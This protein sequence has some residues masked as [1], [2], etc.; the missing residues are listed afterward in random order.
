[1]QVPERLVSTLDKGM[2]VRLEFDAAPTTTWIGTI[3]HV[4]PQADLLSRSFPVKVLLDNRLRDGSPVLR[5]GMLARAWLPVGLVGEALVVPKDAVVL[6]GP[7]PIVFAVQSVAR[8]QTDG[9]VGMGT[10]QP[11]PVRLGAAVGG[12]VAIE[13]DLTVGSLVVIRGNERLRPGM[14]V[15]FPAPAEASR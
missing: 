3:D 1:M 13:G 2:E 11:V 12:A 14:P 7:T 10:V 15:R 9:S 8:A 4:V 6:G 5:G